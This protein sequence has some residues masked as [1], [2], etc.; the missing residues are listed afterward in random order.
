MGAYLLMI[1]RKIPTKS[2]IKKLYKS[3][4]GVTFFWDRGSFGICIKMKEVQLFFF[5]FQNSRPYNNELSRRNRMP[6]RDSA[7]WLEEETTWSK[8]NPHQRD[9][10]RFW[11]EERER[12][13]QAHQH[14]HAPGES[15]EERF[16]AQLFLDWIRNA[17]K[18]SYLP[19]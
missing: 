6:I 7:D 13:A 11:R 10:N 5:I 8:Q 3:R 2:S 12:A 18:K 15:N 17:Q 19:Y 4:G 1:T 9:L 16:L 14:P